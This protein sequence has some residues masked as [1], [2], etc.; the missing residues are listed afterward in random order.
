MNKLSILSLCK[1]LLTGGAAIVIVGIAL[2]FIFPL[3]DK[4]NYST[5]VYAADGT[6]LNA[7]LSKDEKWRIASE[8]P[9]SARCCSRH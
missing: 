1:R 2:H 7:Y 6:L 4:I 9:K 8:K 5:T 3:P